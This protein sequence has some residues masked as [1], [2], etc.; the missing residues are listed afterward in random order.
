MNKSLI[1][2]PG[3]ALVLAACSQAP[4]SASIEEVAPVAQESESTV[5][6][7]QAAAPT[8]Q[9][10]VDTAIAA[11]N[12]T[13]LV[14]AVQAAGLVE[15]LSG[16]GPF[17]VFAPTDEAFAAVP[18][19]TLNALLEDPEALANVLK[20]HV[21]SGKVMADD[22]VNLDSATTVQGSDLTIDTTDGVT[23]NG[24]KVIQADIETSNGVIHV[25]DAVLLPPE[26]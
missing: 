21:V 15:T 18:Q 6:E 25:I 19:A 26:N 13:T 3:L 23:V 17:T 5:V 16:T 14:T 1:L 8:N 20:Y 11:G 12:F 2:I 4:Q 22:V 7:D 24:A 10:I 9:T